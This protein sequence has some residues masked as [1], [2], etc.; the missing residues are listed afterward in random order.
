MIFSNK[1]FKLASGKNPTLFAINDKNM[2]LYLSFNT[3]TK[4]IIE[5]STLTKCFSGVKK[6]DMEFI[7]PLD[8]NFLLGGSNG[9]IK[10]FDKNEN[11]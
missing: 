10:I 8:E 9:I 1:I 7:K 2:E 6:Y 5:V 11:D 4:N 3:S